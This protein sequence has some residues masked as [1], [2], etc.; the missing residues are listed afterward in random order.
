MPLTRKA[1]RINQKSISKP[2]NITKM[3]FHL[4]ILTI[5][6]LGTVVLASAIFENST[7]NV[8]LL[9]NITMSDTD[10]GCGN[11][12]PCCGHPCPPSQGLRLDGP[13]VFGLLV[14]IGAGFVVL[15]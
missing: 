7:T 3:K 15:G 2:H 8:P 12:E 13:Q 6:L 11:I 14:A 5:T 4:L 9:L 10:K 1:Q